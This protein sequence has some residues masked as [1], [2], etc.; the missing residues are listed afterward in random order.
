MRAVVLI[1]STAVL[2]L[3]S[4]ASAQKPAGTA[5][6][7][8]DAWAQAKRNIVDSAKLMPE[9]GYAFRPIETVRTFGQ[10]LAHVAGANYIFCAAARGEKSPHEED[11]FEKT[12][13]GKAEIV[14]ALDA[15]MAYCDASYAAAT[16]ASLAQMVAGPFGGGQQPRAAALLGNTGHLNE[17]YGNLVTY[18]R[19]KG[20]VPPSSAP[21][22]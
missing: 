13:K 22:R 18:F 5:A 15:S 4:A 12:A 17:H 1:A 8:A 3:T 21:R 14:K 6:A 11:H 20:M 9:D 16:D 2:F 10:I 19:M 7:V